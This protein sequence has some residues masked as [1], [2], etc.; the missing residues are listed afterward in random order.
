[1]SYRFE[2][3]LDRVRRFLVRIHDT[4]RARRDYEDD[5]WSF[6]QNCWHLKDW[7]KND[8][9]V[10]SSVS[11]AIEGDVKKCESLMICADLAN[12]SKH[13][14]LHDARRDADMPGR[15]IVAVVNETSGADKPSHTTS[16]VSWDY[17]ITLRDGSERRAMVVAEQAIADWE[18]LIDNW[19]LY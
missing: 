5:L 1:M 19:K 6:F 11:S 13:L 17:R 14:D 15:H 10:P 8:P 16:A 12:R 2:E 9:G 18:T 4:E 3:Q 7:I